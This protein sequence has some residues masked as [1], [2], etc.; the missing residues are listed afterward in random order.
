MS[1][2]GLFFLLS[3]LSV[4]HAN[5]PVNA[6]VVETKVGTII[7]KFNDV[8]VFGKKLKV[9]R[10]LGIPYAKPPLGD[11]RFQKPVPKQPFTSPYK[12]LKHG[13]ICYQLHLLPLVKAEMPESEDCLFLNVYAPARK[14]DCP[15]MIWIHGGAFVVGA[16][17]P[18]VS[19]A[20]A[21]YG[22]VIVVTL[23]YRLSLW[24]FLSTEDVHA[25]G[26][27][28]LFDQHLAIKWVHEN[29]KA[30]GGDPS[31]VTIFGESAGSASVVYQSTFE[32]N[33]GL[34]QRAIAQSGSISAMWASTNHAKNDTEKLAKLIGC[35]NKKSAALVDCI[36]HVSAD[37]L[38]ATIN[39]VT[40]GFITFPCPF[41][42]N[43]DGEFLKKSAKH[44]IK[45][46][47]DILLSERS[48][49][50][51]T[52]DFLT[53]INAAEGA[54]MMGPLAGIADPEQF[55]PNRTYLEGDLIPTALS[56]VFGKDIPQV[57]LDLFI[58]EY[59]VWADPENM[60][61]IRN[62]LMQIYADFMFSA[63]MVETIG[64]HTS[65]SKK[66]KKTYV[67]KF[68]IKPSDSFLPVPSWVENANHMDEL[69]YIFFDEIAGVMTNLPSKD[70]YMPQEWENDI[71][72]YMIT[73]WSNFAKTGNPNKPTPVRMFWPA[74]TK[75]TQHYLHITREM[76]SESVK[77]YLLSREFN[78]CNNIIPAVFRA[79][80]ETK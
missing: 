21:A 56:F 36:K 7:G 26:N 63:P 29:I 35:K 66:S 1:L 2:P 9:E 17:D 25:P 11:L 32:G 3:V 37:S 10:Y 6:P 8:T 4:S 43:V 50:F 54:L 64:Y 34:F 40:N 67:Y 80:H 14:D 65:V 57:M 38:S 12:A 13:N 61:K 22:N 55:E 41:L 53:G 28:G 15:V 51:G 27:Y 23:N 48:P 31:R 5:E 70:G 20:L 72:E 74:Y 49:F 45:V 46:D 30:F 33:R 58:H 69:E 52:L 79:V 62:K 59:K 68:D 71:A 39:N 78:W 19:D 47:P 77:S 44:L 76:T 24:G 60:E 75:E 16:S 73:M 42:P 18:Y